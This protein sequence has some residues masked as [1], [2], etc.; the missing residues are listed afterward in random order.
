MLVDSPYTRG[1]II[2]VDVGDLYIATAICATPIDEF[3][4]TFSTHRLW[5]VACNKAWKWRT[6]KCDF[7]EEVN[8]FDRYFNDYYSMPP[9]HT[10]NNGDSVIGAPWPLAIAASLLRN[11]AMAR[12]EVWTMPVG[13][14]VWL[15]TAI[16]EQTSPGVEILS[17]DKLEAMYELGYR[18]RPAKKG[19]NA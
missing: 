8:A 10:E 3:S 18:V 19:K 9:T 13:E 1:G 12:K 4:N 5:P 17:G 14:A 11:T 6:R 15:Q 16:A 7:K 2:K